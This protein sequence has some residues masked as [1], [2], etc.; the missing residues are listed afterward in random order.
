MWEALRWVNMVLAFVALAMMVGSVTHAW[1]TAPRHDRHIGLAHCA[2]LVTIAYGSGEALTQ[3]VPPGIRIV[4]MAG[5]LVY[6]IIGLLMR[7]KSHREQAVGRP[8][9]PEG[10]VV[11][12]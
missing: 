4:L 1:H 11:A 9:A 2:M 7:V 3:S 5:S 6:L 12:R 8:S 10:R